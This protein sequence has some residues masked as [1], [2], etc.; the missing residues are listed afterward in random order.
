MRFFERRGLR[1]GVG[2]TIVSLV[3]LA[4]LVGFLASIA[5]PLSQ[6]ITALI[7]ATPGYLQQLQDRS[8]TLGRLNEQLHLTERAQALAPEGIGTQ[9]AGSLLAVGSAVAAGS[10]TPS[11][12][13]C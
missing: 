5:A 6:E 8:S 1:R 12:C 7:D 9:T 2:V 4:L 10:S 13:S 3:T 11:S